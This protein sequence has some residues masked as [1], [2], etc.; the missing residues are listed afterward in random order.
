MNTL[1]IILLIAGFILAC[2]TAIIY[3]DS[4]IGKVKVVGALLTTLVYWV[5][6]LVILL[7]LQGI[8][9]SI[10]DKIKI[11]I[12][13]EI[14]SID[15]NVNIEHNTVFI[16]GTGSINSEYCY[17]FYVKYGKNELAFKLNNVSAKNC[18]IIEDEE[19]Q[20]YIIKSKKVVLKNPKVWENWI[21]NNQIK[22]YESDETIEIH[23]P[24]GTI[25]QE[26]KGRL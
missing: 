24:K 22:D 25:V 13:T 26:L 5:I 23:V 7:V 4:V 19:H 3:F 16:L 14:Y 15:K 18:V 10:A 6:V 20:P 11:P 2:L 21:T 12:K 1:F 8:L 9:D 17:N